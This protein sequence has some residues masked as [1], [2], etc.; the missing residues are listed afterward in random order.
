MKSISLSI[1]GRLFGHHTE[2]TI[3]SNGDWYKAN[4][5]CLASL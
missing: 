4:R 2:I 3:D 1:F 5:G